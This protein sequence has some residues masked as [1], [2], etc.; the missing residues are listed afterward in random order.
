VRGGGRRRDRGQT[1]V[2][3]ALI[4]PIFIVLFFGM[5]EF[6]FLFNAQLS[7]NFA[8][9]DASLLAAEAGTSDGNADCVVLRKVDEDLS[10]PT[11]ETRVLRV[12]ISADVRRTHEARTGLHPRRLEPPNGPS[13]RTHSARP[14]PYNR[15]AQSRWLRN[16]APRHDRRF[17]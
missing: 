9:R 2:E 8:T 16:R 14:F 13:V 15:A 3:F 5:I 4:F 11:D 7:L 6:G 1:L 12:H 10:A 17:H